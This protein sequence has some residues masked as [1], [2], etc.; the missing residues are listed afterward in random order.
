MRHRGVG[1]VNTSFNLCQVQAIV[2]AVFD[3]DV[4]HEGHVGTGA[5][6]GALVVDA[7]AL[8]AERVESGVQDVRVLHPR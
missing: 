4:V 1:N 2:G 3:C 7:D 5:N 8:P 6:G